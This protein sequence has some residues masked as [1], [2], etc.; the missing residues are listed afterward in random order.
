MHIWRH[1][2]CLPSTVSTSFFKLAIFPNP[3]TRI[4]IAINLWLRSSISPDY[5]SKSGDAL[6]LVADALKLII[7]ILRRPSLEL[8]N[9]L[10]II[11]QT[12][13]VIVTW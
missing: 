6:F 8:S 3:S 5:R 9:S 13:V 4:I 2:P 7:I 12:P 1:T 10:I 11:G